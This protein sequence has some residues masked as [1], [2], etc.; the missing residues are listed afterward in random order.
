MMKKVLSCIGK[1][2]IYA[3]I[4]PILVMLEVVGEVLIPIF[5]AKMV[6]NGIMKG[7]MDVVLINGAI[8]AGLA[9]ISLFFG[10]VSGKAAVKASTGL[11][12]GIRQKEMEKI[13]EFSSANI[14][15]YSTASL[16][17]RLTTDITH[18]Q[19]AFQS[20]IRMAVRAPFMMIFSTIMAFTLNSKLASMF[21][22]AIPVLGLALF[23]IAKTAYPR[24]HKMMKKY[25][26]MEATIQE[27][28][29][30]IRTVKSF[31]RDDY[32][33]E[34]FNQTSDDVYSFSKMAEKV[35]LLNNPIMQFVL[36]TCMLLAAWFGGQLVISS[37]MTTGQL[38]SFINYIQQILFSLMMITMSGVMIVMA[39]SSFRRIKEI[40]VE[41]PDIKD[42]QSDQEMIDASIEF[43]NVGF[44]YAKDPNKLVLSDI[45]LKIESGET[46]GIIGGTGS[47]KTTLVQLISRLYDTTLGEVF[48]GGHNVKEYKL[49]TLRDQV[50]MVL[51]K[52]ILFSG[53]IKE[54]LKWGNEQATDEQIIQ[55]CKDAQAHD[56]IMSFPNKYETELGQGGV[57]VS[58]G[59]KQRLCI[60]RALLKNPKII[61][62]DDSTSAVDTATDSKIRAAFKRNLKDTTTIIIAQ[63]ITSVHDADRIIVMDKGKIVSVGTHDELL[64]SCSIYQEVYESQQKGVMEQ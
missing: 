19:M 10:V 34:K 25:D 21:L 23:F 4:A 39:T 28:L 38:M 55:A 45:N 35:L 5:M 16:I 1:Y 48:V 52:N 64:K 2:K 40:L 42:S 8:M 58:G 59:Q 13:Q 14:D 46:I 31:V 60:A 37:V 56:F 44:S 9:I 26:A 49:Q 33:E 50:A 53:T 29:I 41:E 3:I 24:F 11:S 54:N 63:R 51:Q 7:D 30:A 62:L 43:K 61:I 47:S 57:N 20:S 36:Y 27:N 15:K 22:L 32:E 12:E 17:T 6:D 18:V